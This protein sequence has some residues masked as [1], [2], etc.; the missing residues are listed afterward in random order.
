[1]NPKLSLL[2]ICLNS[3]QTI[4]DTIE[5]VLTQDCE[6]FE[7]V[8]YDGGSQDETLNI[9]RSFGDRIKLVE[10]KDNGIYDA[11]NAGLSHTTGEVLGF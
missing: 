1:M 9:L 7:Y 8:V 6:D 4:R 2:T 3:E 10:G 11:F 5:S